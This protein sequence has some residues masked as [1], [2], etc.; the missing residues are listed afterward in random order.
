MTWLMHIEKHVD[1][2]GN[3]LWL[4]KYIILEWSFQST[5]CTYLTI[6]IELNFEVEVFF[7]VIIYKY[8]SIYSNGLKSIFSSKLFQFT[9]S[10]SSMSQLR[11]EVIEVRYSGASVASIDLSL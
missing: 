5:A 9:H 8:L 1:F 3:E 7:E 4:N 11:T 10:V 2:I 6:Q